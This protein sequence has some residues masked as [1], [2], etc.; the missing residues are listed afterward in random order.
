MN[1]PINFAACVAIEKLVTAEFL[2]N[3]NSESSNGYRDHKGTYF[4][5]EINAIMSSTFQTVVFG[6]NFNGLG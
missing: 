2:A 5:D 6:A 1:E 4:T 3:P